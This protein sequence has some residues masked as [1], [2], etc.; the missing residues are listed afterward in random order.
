MGTYNQTF[1]PEVINSY[2]DGK[3]LSALKR[4]DEQ[5]VLESLAGLRPEEI[6]VMKFLQE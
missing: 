4:N 1:L 3:L 6:A 2:L 5:A